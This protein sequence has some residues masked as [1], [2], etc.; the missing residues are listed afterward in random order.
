MVVLGDFPFLRKEAL[1]EPLP[2][3]GYVG[4]TS[5]AGSALFRAADGRTY[6]LKR[7]GLGETGFSDQG[8]KGSSPIAR[9]DEHY[10]HT[11]TALSGL[12][13]R[14]SAEL[15]F[16]LA[17]KFRQVALST[18]YRPCGIVVPRTTDLPGLGLGTLDRPIAAVLMEI[19]SD[20]R[21]DELVYM[22][23]TPLLASL[24]AT[25]RLTYDERYEVFPIFDSDGI[26]LVGTR[27]T[28]AH[29]SERL[30][31]IGSAVGGVY[32]RCHDAGFLRGL[33]SSWPGNEVVHADGRISMIDFD[34]GIAESGAYPED[35]ADLL[36]RT[37]I[38]QY[39]ADSYLFFTVLRPRTLQLYGED[40]I[41]GCWA[42][43]RDGSPLLPIDLLEAILSD[44]SE[45]GP[46]LW[47]GTDFASDSA[48]PLLRPEGL[49]LTAPE[50]PDCH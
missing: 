32:R 35:I 34:G 15:E 46:Q 14:A 12:M 50:V 38:Q 22:T 30:Y 2:Q 33:T 7:C 6:K 24:F 1:S 21:I 45:A 40:F 3:N 4:L 8:V 36:R 42:G 18:A 41:E 49:V 26:P 25:G 9:D 47:D 43:Y 16:H 44:H 10:D 39:C 20:L 28:W 31:T 27:R 37:E 19:E 5:G 48:T 23:M 17:N 11:G 29:L 13:S